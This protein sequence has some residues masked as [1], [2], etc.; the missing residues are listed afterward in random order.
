[1]LSLNFSI[2]RHLKLFLILLMKQLEYPFS[3]FQ[4]DRCQQVFKSKTALLKHKICHSQGPYCYTCER[5]PYSTSFQHEMKH[6]RLLHSNKYFRCQECNL[7]F[8][9]DLVFEQHMEIHKAEKLFKCTICQ[10]NFRH[11]EELKIHKIKH[12]GWY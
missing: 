11:D 8:S 4:C 7:I 9:S 1:M 10:K 6:H 5:C 3:G 12:L 2:F